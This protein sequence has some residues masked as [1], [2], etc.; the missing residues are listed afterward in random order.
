MTRCLYPKLK[1]ELVI[2]FIKIVIN[3]L[4]QLKV[5]FALLYIYRIALLVFFPAKLHK[6]QWLLQYFRLEKSPFT[7][8]KLFFL[9][10]AVPSMYKN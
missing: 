10:V 5:S 6:F 4:Y 9:M 3:L 7:I 2:K 1:S 8:N